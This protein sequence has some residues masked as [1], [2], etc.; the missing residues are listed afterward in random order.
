MRA[1][2]CRSVA[3]TN[4]T[5]HTRKPWRDYTPAQRAWLV[6]LAALELGLA[7]A[8]WADLAHRDPAEVRGRKWVWGLV[9]AI[10]IVGPLAYFRWGRRA[11]VAEEPGD[12]GGSSEETQPVGRAVGEA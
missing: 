10:N 7:A 5:G 9:I 4:S 2:C 11:T 1:C 3:N 6:A 8:A 12:E